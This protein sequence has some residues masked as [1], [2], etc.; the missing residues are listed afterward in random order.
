MAFLW[1]LTAVELKHKVLVT[2]TVLKNQT[3]IDKTP[4]SIFINAWNVLSSYRKKAYKRKPIFI[5]TDKE[6]FEL[7]TSKKGYFFEI[8]PVSNLA[9][10]E[11]YDEEHNQLKID[12]IHPFYF[13]IHS[14]PIE[15]I[16]DIDDTV[17]HSHTASALKRI[18]TILFKRPKRRN[19]IL[20]SNALLDFFDEND[21]RISYLSKS[22]S[23]LFGLI[24]AIFRFNEIPIG[25]LFLTP[26]IRF[27]SLFKPKKGKHKID[28]L[29]HIFTNSPDKKFILIGDD[30]QKDMDIYTEIVNSYESQIIK[31]YIRQ[32]TFT[33]NEIQKKKWEALKE[34][35]VECMYF[36]D[37]D[38]I[39]KEIDQLKEFSTLT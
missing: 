10:F 25:P 27:K 4:R 38:D 12:Q 29:H 17:I 23:N 11:I 6:T 28:F 14:T 13:Q 20:F 16:S 8:L 26:Y 33:V 35:G 32:T 22:E 5:K 3:S 9:D 34:T 2:G 19:K 37:D 1:H 36:Q 18:S 31:V 30:T 21:F 24:T 15:V 39:N 7:E